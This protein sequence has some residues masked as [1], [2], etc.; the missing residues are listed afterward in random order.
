MFRLP[1]PPLRPF[2]GASECYEL[3]ADLLDDA[4]SVIAERGYVT[5]LASV[6]RPF[7]VL[8][9]T[10]GR[11][12]FPAIR[13]DRRCDDLN[14]WHEDG[15]PTPAPLPSIE[16]D[17]EFLDGLRQ[18]DPEHP[19]RNLTYWAG[20]RV[21]AWGNPARRDGWREDVWRVLG[22][23]LLVAPLYAPTAAWNLVALAVDR[24][25]NR[26]ACRLTRRPLVEVVAIPEPA[27]TERVAA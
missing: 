1:L 5:D 8:L 17:R 7:R 13:H 18:T 6:P 24:A 2:L 21:G 10:A 15:R 23:L 4:G 3:T 14:A 12:T 27:D 9:P 16:A 25:A 11:V 19:L 22:V 20:V 26:I